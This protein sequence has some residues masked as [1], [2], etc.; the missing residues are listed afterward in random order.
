[1]RLVGL[2][3]IVGLLMDTFGFFICCFRRKLGVDEELEASKREKHDT[4]YFK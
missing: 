1:M 4:D 3:E 2:W